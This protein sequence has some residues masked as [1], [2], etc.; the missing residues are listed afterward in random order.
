M[1]ILF[2]N[3]VVRNILM[4]CCCYL[5]WLISFSCY[6]LLIYNKDLSQ[7]LRSNN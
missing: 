4:F 5:S 6:Q 1:L 2:T 3:K 7:Y